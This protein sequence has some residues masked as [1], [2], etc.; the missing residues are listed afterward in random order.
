MARWASVTSFSLEDEGVFLRSAPRA[1]ESGHARQAFVHIQEGS[2]RAVARS[3]GRSEFRSRSFIADFAGVTLMV[4][5]GAHGTVVSG[6]TDNLLSSRSLT[7]AI[8]ARG[9]RYGSR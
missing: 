1:H 3:H 9:T 8:V 4:D 2:F 5:I 6:R 7:R